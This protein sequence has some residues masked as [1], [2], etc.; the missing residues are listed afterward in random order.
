MILRPELLGL[1]HEHLGVFCARLD[2][3][4]QGWRFIRLLDPKGKNTGSTLLV[5]FGISVVE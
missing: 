1:R 3:L 5:R 4:Q 2:H